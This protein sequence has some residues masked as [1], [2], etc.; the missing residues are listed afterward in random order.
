MAW[1][2]SVV[3]VLFLFGCGKDQP[4]GPVN[5]DSN[6]TTVKGRGV[7]ILNEGNYNWKNASLSFFNTDS[8][9]LSNDIYNTANSRPLGDVAQSMVIKDSLGYI[10]VNNSKVIEVIHTGTYKSAGTISGFNSPRFM[11]IINSTKAY[12]T[13][14]YNNSIYIVNYTA[15]SITGQITVNGWTEQ[16]VKYGD[17]VFVCNMKES[18]VLVVNSLTD[19]VADTINTIKEPNSIVIDKFNKIWVLCS[20]GYMHEQVPALL[21]IDAAT[22]V[23]ETTF[24]FP[25]Q[26]LS[27]AELTINK[28]GDT[29]YYINE[30]IYRMP[31]SSTSL[32]TNPF[33][34]KGSRLFYGLGIAPDN[35]W[36]YAS[37]AIDYVQCGYIYR[38][39][40][41][42]AC[43]DS[44]KAGII[45]G[46]FC[47]N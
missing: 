28:W 27:P 5:S 35:S 16:M 2:I 17:Y 46:F 41:D 33:I 9:R 36:I 24:Q 21:K 43:V 42:G 37:D 34:A 10:L 4:I 39:K 31:V 20:G 19:L 25:S 47:F 29:L 45:P 40:P 6:H 12:V 1:C 23:I 8:C 18:S 22:V 13:D 44:L 38:Y 15:R 32:P 7:F 14:L 3:F 26:N 30:G 11:Q